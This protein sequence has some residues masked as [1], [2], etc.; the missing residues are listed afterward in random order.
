MLLS[1]THPS[2]KFGSAAPSRFEHA[3]RPYTTAERH[4]WHGPGIRIREESKLDKQIVRLLLD[5]A[6]ECRKAKTF[7][8]DLQDRAGELGA[9][10]TAISRA[11]C[12]ESSETRK[13]VDEIVRNDPA[14]TAAVILKWMNDGK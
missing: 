5:A 4:S 9:L 11:K 7:V 13:R 6:V 2:D 12:F 3:C 1:V 8:D 10:R 14:A